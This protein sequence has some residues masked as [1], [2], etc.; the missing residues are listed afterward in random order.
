MLSREDVLHIAKL[1][2]LQLSDDEI[3]KNRSQLSDVLDLFGKIDDLKLD[4]IGETSQVSGL[5][6]VFKKD[7]LSCDDNLCPCNWEK[8]LSNVPYSRDSAILAPK[9]IEDR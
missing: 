1:A 8:L 4:E 9:V 6:N 7:E 3:E 5:N 2:R